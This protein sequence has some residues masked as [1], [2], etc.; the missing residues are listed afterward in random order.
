[1]NGKE[2]CR[3]ASLM[4]D[5]VHFFNSELLEAGKEKPRRKNTGE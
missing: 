5:N 1:M 3:G 4:Y 2:C